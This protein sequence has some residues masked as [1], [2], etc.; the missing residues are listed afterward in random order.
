MGGFQR[1]RRNFGGVALVVALLLGLT[2]LPPDTSL[3]EIRSTETLKACVPRLYPPLVT[4]NLERPGV[5]IELLRAIAER[6]GVS[7]SLSTNDAMGRDFNPRN[8]S[9]NRAQCHVVA[10]GVVDS[11][12]TRSFLETSSSYAQTG[13]AVVAPAPVGSLDGLQVGALALM[14]GLDRKG[15]ASYLRSSGA[16]ARVVTAPDALVA[17]IEDGTFDIGVTEALLATRLATENDWSVAWAA[18]ELARYNIV[19][20]LWKGDITLKRAVNGALAELAADG[21]LQAI[22]DRYDVAPIK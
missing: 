21:S 17:G 8:W 2:L 12:Q 18:P 16:A 3:S 19:I 15:L 13:W 6:I 1:L 5:D 11:T 10:G 22:F 14:S 20:G 7:L 4:G 9:L